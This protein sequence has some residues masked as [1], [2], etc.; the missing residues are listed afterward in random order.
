MICALIIINSGRNTNSNIN[1][2]DT[3]NSNNTNADNITNT[4][5]IADEVNTE[6]WYIANRIII[7]TIIIFDLNPK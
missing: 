1:T 5:W 6:D 2:I 3:G 4:N 7:I